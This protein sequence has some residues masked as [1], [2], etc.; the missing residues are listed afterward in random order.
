MNDV[1]LNATR[2]ALEQC[3]EHL[4]V[5]D[6]VRQMKDADQKVNRMDSAIACVQSNELII[7]SRLTISRAAFYESLCGPIEEMYRLVIAIM[8]V[9]VLS[10][11]TSPLK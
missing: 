3:N 8:R 2:V 10:M 7:F 5:Y 6:D 9:F 11:K 4:R 1:V